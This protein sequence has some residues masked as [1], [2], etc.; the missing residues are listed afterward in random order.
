VEDE[1]GTGLAGMARRA[2]SEVGAVFAALPPDAAERMG[3]AI[4]AAGRIVCYGVGREGLMVKA[5]AMRPV[6]SGVSC[7]ASRMIAIWGRGLLG[8]LV[9]G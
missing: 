2:L 8:V 4:L 9:C 1:R 6:P 7:A 5:L 3:D